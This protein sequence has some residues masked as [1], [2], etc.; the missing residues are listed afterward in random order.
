MIIYMFKKTLPLYID[1]LLIKKDEEIEGIDQGRM[2][3]MEWIGPGPIL[4]IMMIG[5]QTLS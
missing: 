4:F 5:G 2:P 1:A 3:I